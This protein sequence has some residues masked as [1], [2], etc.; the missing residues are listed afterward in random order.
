[1][2]FVTAPAALSLVRAGKLRPLAVTTRK[3]TPAA[4]EIPTV[5]EQL[6]LP[7]YEVDSWV[8]LFAP[9]RTP[10]PILERMNRELVRV[11]SLPDIRQRLIEQGAD[12][13][14]SSPEALGR[15]VRSELKVW[16]AVIRTADIKPE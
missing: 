4:P 1:V 11:L 8:A 2:L 7:D 13:V 10:A 9:A 3:R 14:G 6:N 16:A 5:A 12:P 15:L